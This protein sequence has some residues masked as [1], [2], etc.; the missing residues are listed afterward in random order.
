MSAVVSDT[1]G[2]GPQFRAPR[3]A[4]ILATVGVIYVGA[5]SLFVL[6]RSLQLETLYR[7]GESGAVRNMMW[8]ATCLSVAVL[9]CLVRWA[10]LRVD[11]DGVRWGFTTLGFRMRRD[12]LALAKVYSDAI[13]LVPKRGVTTWYLGRRDWEG[14][15]ELIAAFKRAGL[16]MTDE[17][18]R[19]PLYGRLQVYGRALDAL[20]LLDI[21]SI[22]FVAL[23][24]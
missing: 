20:Y 5:L 2:Q 19:A 24:L 21:A 10:R 1:L 16:T 9:G 4:R 3:R 11:T 22:S 6:W 14:F 7:I 15:D 17:G 12:A 18:R 13:A 23:M 8:A